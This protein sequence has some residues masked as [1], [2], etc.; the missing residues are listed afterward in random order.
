[1]PLGLEVDLEQAICVFREA[2]LGVEHVLADP[3]PDVLPWEFKENNVILRV[4]WWT[5]SQRS[6]EVRTRAA[7]VFAIKRASEQ[8]RIAIP[9]DTK[10]SFADT[11]LLIARAAK[12]RTEPTAVA[13]S[14]IV[15]SD[16]AKLAAPEAVEQAHDPEAEKPKQ[17]EL[18]EGLEELPR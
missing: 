1:V 5:K 15:D 4:R 2:V 12:P 17:G 14:S 3:P 7:V 13:P 18:N 9:A 16:E 11:P 8:A 6:Y 10:I